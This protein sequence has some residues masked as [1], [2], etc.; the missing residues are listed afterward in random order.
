MS[1]AGSSA[2]AALAIAVMAACNS[3]GTPPRADRA[4][5]ATASVEV[6]PKPRPAAPGELPAAY[7]SGPLAYAA[8][9][10]GT[11]GNLEAAVPPMCYTRTGGA[12]NPCWVCHTRGIG[13]TSLDDSDLQREYSFG[14][15]ALANHWR[16]LFV[17]RRPFIAGVSD[18]EIVRWVRADNYAP[19]R[20]A[21]AA[22]PARYTGFR[23]D[24][25]L[26]RGFDEHGLARDGSGWRAVR[27]QPFPGAF[28][29][30]NGSASDVF[31]RLPDRFRRAVGGA[32]S[33]EI[34]R[35]NLSIVEAAISVEDYGKKA[36]DREIEP[37]DERLLGFD[38][39][40]DG[41]LRD[42][43]TRVRRL[44][45]TYAGAAAGIAVVAQAFP[46]GT[47]L[48]H[49][50]RYLDPDAPSMRA[51][52]MKELR[53][54]RKIEDPDDWGRQRAY[55][56]EA[57]DKAAGKP[58][59]YQGDPEVG[60]ITPWGWQLQGYIEDAA[61][62]LRVQTAEEHRFCMGCHGHIGVT[63]DQTFSIA[64]KVPGAAGW[65]HQDLR[66]L[67][68]RP[69]VGHSA[70]ELVT[71]FARARGGDETRSNE[72]LLARFFPGGVLA[73]AELRRAAAGGDRDLAWALSPTRERALAL[74][75]AYLAIV[76][77][78]SFVRG[79]DAMLAP[80]TR[81]HERI[82]ETGTGLG[83]TGPAHARVHRD[84]RLHLDWR[85]KR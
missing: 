65:R 35:L 22:L 13:R 29:P 47:E 2:T 28:W 53:Y 63:I 69:Q 1:R 43:T 9:M 40:G 72:E 73:E 70:P 54:M 81:V 39:D 21:M 15:A 76:R 84:G 44:P 10:A 51:A 30:T 24:L 26:A 6:K 38:L 34:Y 18:D 55:A 79:R 37:V 64:R 4:D 50:V 3:G 52:R 5:F 12:S 27:F 85:G 16:N 48:L 20:A 33:A 59:A 74:D 77:E 11:V 45:K 78:Q 23:P 62:A 19:L 68:D 32:P 75:K 7:A 49:S 56:E 80:A 14:D 66:G 83:E 36:V 46:L 8:A 25:D 58:P 17:D 60:L 61:G 57:E 42:G 67:Q 41:A 82:T 71:Y 31:I